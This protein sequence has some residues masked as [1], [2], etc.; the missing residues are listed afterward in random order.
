M[1]NRSGTGTIS[2]SPWV[3]PCVFL[4][5]FRVFRDPGTGTTFLILRF[6]L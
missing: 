2:R 3:I 5:N 4:G 1:N 6:I